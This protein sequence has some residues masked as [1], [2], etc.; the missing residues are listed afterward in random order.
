MSLGPHHGF[1][2]KSLGLKNTEV[3]DTEEFGART[4]Y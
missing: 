4:G 3:G 2:M 1:V